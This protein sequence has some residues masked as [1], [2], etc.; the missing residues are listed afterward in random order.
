MLVA[1]NQRVL[2]PRRKRVG[3][4]KME[5]SFFLARRLRWMDNCG[6]EHQFYC[7][8]V[9]QVGEKPWSLL[10][11]DKRHML[12][13]V[14]VN[15]VLLSRFRCVDGVFDHRRHWQVFHFSTYA[16]VD[17]GISISTLRLDHFRLLQKVKSTSLDLRMDP[18]VDSLL[19]CNIWVVQAKK[20][21]LLHLL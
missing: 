14:K 3:M 19:L 2:E 13:I 12:G 20:F 5:G 15:V 10:F 8:V 1:F 17:G 16:H 4:E 6:S 18:E 11:K 7:L 9:N 21:V